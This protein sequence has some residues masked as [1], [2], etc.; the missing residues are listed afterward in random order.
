MKKPAEGSSAAS[1]GTPTNTSLKVFVDTA[2][3]MEKLA[4]QEAGHGWQGKHTNLVSRSFGSWLFLGELLLS[5]ELPRRRAGAGPLRPVPRLP[6]FLPDQR[7]PRA[8]PARCPALHL[9]S[10]RSSMHGPIDREFRPRA[11]QPHLWLR[12]LPR[13]LPVEQ[14]RRR[15]ARAPS[16]HAAELQRAVAG[17][18]GRTRRRR[19]PHAL[20]RHAR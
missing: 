8:L 13:G 10:H 4:A 12:R 18:T 20:L 15:R 17:R 1:S 14:V 11:G 3:L 6:R 7:L 9:L 2:P 19:V 5:I 16:R